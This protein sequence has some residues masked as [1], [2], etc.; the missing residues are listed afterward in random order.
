MNKN[1]LIEEIAKQAD[2]SKSKAAEALGAFIN[3]VETT[4]KK[5]QDVVIAGFGTFTAVDRAARTARN[6]RTGEAV[7]VQAVRV[8]KFRAGT[9]LKESVQ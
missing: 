2:I 9:K 7:Q 5:R 6:P 1:E 8:P 4:L 3:A